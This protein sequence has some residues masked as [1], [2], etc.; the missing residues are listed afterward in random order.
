MVAASLGATPADKVAEKLV[1]Y[2]HT[3]V[4]VMPSVIYRER[5]EEHTTSKF[6]PEAKVY[7]KE[8]YEQLMDASEQG[9]Y[10]GKFRVASTSQMERTIEELSFTVDDLGDPGELKELAR[11]A[12]VDT[13]VAL[14]KDQSADRV[15]HSLIEGSTGDV[16]LSIDRVNAEIIE[17]SSGHATY[18]Q[19]FREDRT[20]GKTAYM[21]ESWEVRRWK[22]G[23][24]RNEGFDLDGKLPFG[25]GRKWERYQYTKLKRN[26]DNPLD[27]DDFPYNI[28]IY[29]GDSRRR[30]EKFATDDGDKY[31]VALNDGDVYRLSVQNDSDEP[32]YM[33]VYI[34]GLSG[35][36]RELLEPGD[37]E[38]RRHWYLPPNDG[39]RIIAGWYVIDRNDDGSAKGE[40]QYYNEFKI[41]PREKS[42]A[43]GKSFEKNIGMITLI[44]YTVGMDG[45]EE[46]DDDDL[47]LKARGLPAVDFGTGLGNRK[48]QRLEFVKKAPRGLMLAAQ[49]IYYRTSEQ[50]SDLRN[51]KGDD[52]VLAKQEHTQRD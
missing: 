22:N 32:V 38:T 21:G 33:A 28:K 2:G 39:E 16:R 9:K 26:L 27:I 6:G 23:K 43:F 44:F 50:V 10:K 14:T 20:L 7:A 17:V 35:I 41:V 25:K 51:G 15:V 5:E 3:R 19:D 34:D 12:G 11:W 40:M 42:V 1:E 18:S 45:I 36:D 29:V 13:I 4:G 24:L 30:P 48:D 8:L 46:P 47:P 52:P 37:L 49:T 31:V